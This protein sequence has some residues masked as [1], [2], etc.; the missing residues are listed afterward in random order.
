M[1][2]GVHYLPEDDRMDHDPSDRCLCG[3][4]RH[5]LD[6]PRYGPPVFLMVHNRLDGKPAEP[7]WPALT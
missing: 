1:A 2:M 4:R 6:N 7:E 5:L 3:V